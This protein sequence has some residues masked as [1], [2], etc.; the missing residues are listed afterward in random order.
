MNNFLLNS[1]CLI[2]IIPSSLGSY[3]SLVDIYL[4]RV[5]RDSAKTVK[6][7]VKACFLFLPVKIFATHFTNVL[8]IASLLA[9]SIIIIHR[10]RSSIKSSR[11]FMAIITI[12]M[13]GKAER[14]DSERRRKTCYAS[15][16]HRE[17]KEDGR[18][19][20]G[21]SARPR[22]RPYVDLPHSSSRRNQD[23]YCA[24]DCRRKRQRSRSPS[25]SRKKFKPTTSDDTCGP[26]HL[27]AAECALETRNSVSG[28]RS[29]A[30]SE[31][32]HKSGRSRCDS[33]VAGEVRKGW[34]ASLPEC[35]YSA[36][37]DKV[38]E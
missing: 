14:S 24:S 22:H 19:S 3:T 12:K 11:F 37:E 16:F 31:V 38:K 33:V 30:G 7:I 5:K 10:A 29:T 26:S 18:K 21:S 6:H 36:G 4:W 23:N 8:K 20:C 35:Y 9:P 25:V 28:V 34:T 17:R 1:F 13:S 27:P 15:S 2:R 32:R